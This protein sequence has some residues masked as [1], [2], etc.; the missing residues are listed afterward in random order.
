M[1]SIAVLLMINFA[2]NWKLFLSGDT[3]TRKL[4]KMRFVVKGSGPIVSPH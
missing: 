4:I 3:N 2:E 1:H